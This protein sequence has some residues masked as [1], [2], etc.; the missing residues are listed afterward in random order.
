MG[1]HDLVSDALFE[2]E[3]ALLK[4]LDFKRE[5][6]LHLVRFVIDPLQLQVRQVTVRGFEERAVQQVVYFLLVDLKE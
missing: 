6:V 5:Q 1:R 2:Q 4:R 3:H